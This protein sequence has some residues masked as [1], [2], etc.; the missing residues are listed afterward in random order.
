MMDC[1]VIGDSIAVGMQMYLRECKLKGKGGINSFQ[2]NKMYP[3]LQNTDVAVISLGTN[4]HAG[5]KT[6]QELE[7]MRAKVHARKVYWILPHG[8]KPASRVPIESLRLI[9]KSVAAEHG[10]VVINFDSAPAR[11]RIHPSSRGYKEMVASVK[12]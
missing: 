4:D 12:P 9:V 11:D 6:R 8:N 5:V 10:D 7:A 3:V 2:W 1:M